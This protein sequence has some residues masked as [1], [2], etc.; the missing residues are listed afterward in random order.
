MFFIARKSLKNKPKSLESPLNSLK[1]IFEI[2]Q[3][4]F[5]IQAKTHWQTK[6]VSKSELKSS[7]SIFSNWSGYGPWPTK[8]ALTPKLL[9]PQKSFIYENVWNQIPLMRT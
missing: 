4:V 7:N 2:S 5:E 9:K 6:N 1:R 3:G 8:A